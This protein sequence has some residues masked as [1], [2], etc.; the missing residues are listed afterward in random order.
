[1]VVRIFIGRHDDIDFVVSS[2]IEKLRFLLNHPQC[3]GCNK[4][5]IE[6][7]KSYLKETFFKIGVFISVSVAVFSVFCFPTIIGLSIFHQ[8]NEHFY[9]FN[10][11][12]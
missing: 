6:D 12:Q 2:H 4:Q 3:S 11:L 5:G 10:H 8:K 1:M 9:T 7:I